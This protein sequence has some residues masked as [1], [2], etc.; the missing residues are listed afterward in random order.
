MLPVGFLEQR[1]HDKNK[2]YCPN[3]HEWSYQ[4]GEF[5]RIR[6]ER[7]MLKQQIARAEQERNEAWAIV[8]SQR[9]QRIAAEKLLKQAQTR[10]GAGICPCCN[11]TFAQLAKHMKSKHPDVPFVPA[12]KPARGRRA[13]P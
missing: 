13:L 3:G 10:I 6:R 12:A 11:R 8:E 4:E 7:D 1:R 2:W 9:Q 5:D